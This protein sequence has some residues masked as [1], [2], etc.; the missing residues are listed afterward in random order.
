MPAPPEKRR[1]AL[2]SRYSTDLQSERSVE[3]QLAL[4]E[5]FAIAQGFPA[6]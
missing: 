3:D 1:A 4:C 5:G 6:T 2:Y